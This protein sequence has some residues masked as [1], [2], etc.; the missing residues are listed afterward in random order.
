MKATW[1]KKITILLLIIIPI[2]AS[3]FL[4]EQIATAKI[5]KPKNPEI[6]SVESKFE[7]NMVWKVITI[8]N[9][10]LST[11]T[12]EKDR[13]TCDVYTLYAFQW[14]DINHKT[15]VLDV[16]SSNI[17]TIFDHGLSSQLYLTCQSDQVDWMDIPNKEVTIATFCPG[18]GVEEMRVKT[19]ITSKARTHMSTHYVEAESEWIK[20]EQTTTE[21]KPTPKDPLPAPLSLSLIVATCITTTIIASCTYYN[22]RVFQKRQTQ[23][24]KSLLANR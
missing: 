23:G 9:Q 5:S 11:K 20:V 21:D 22:R 19:L 13:Q 2:A 4:T 14:I 16:D 7:D 15:W 8:K 12:I 17:G 24:S 6:L 18:Y 3:S 10:P 1:S